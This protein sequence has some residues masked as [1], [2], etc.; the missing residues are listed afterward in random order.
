MLALTR[1]SSVKSFPVV[2]GTVG[3]SFSGRQQA[4]AARSWTFFSSSS[5]K[6][7]GQSRDQ[8]RRRRGKTASF[9]YEDGQRPADTST[10][11]ATSLSLSKYPNDASS[12]SFEW[13][14]GQ[15]VLVEVISFGPLGAS[16]N[17]VATSHDPPPEEEEWPILGQGLISQQEITYFRAARDNIDVVRGEVLPAYIERIRPQ[18]GKVSIGLRVFGG[19]EKAQTTS[20][21]I[22]AALEAGDG[23]LDVGDKSDPQEIAARFPGVSK[24][25]FKKAVS[26]LFKQGKIQKPGAYEIQLK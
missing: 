11:A 25:T 15:K 10:S 18:D 4:A 7:R 9:K 6:S 8:S 5:P 13:K 1:I 19:K 20:Q 3:R 14:P 17:V 21:Q 16:V 22:M 2:F 12:A 26:A 24:S 23:V